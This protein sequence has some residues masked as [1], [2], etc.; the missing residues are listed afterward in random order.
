MMNWE[1]TV[2]VKKEK[3]QADMEKH[4]TMN[5]NGGGVPTSNGPYGYSGP[6]QM[7]EDGDSF[8]MQG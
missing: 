5:N 7:E 2:E 4:A 1:E 8:K 6:S 3:N